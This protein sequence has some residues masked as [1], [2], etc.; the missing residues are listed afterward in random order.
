MSNR[1]NSISTIS[2]VRTILGM[3]YITTALTMGFLDIYEFVLGAV[4]V[5][6]STIVAIIIILVSMHNERVAAEKARRQR[7]TMS[8]EENIKTLNQTLASY[9]EITRKLSESGE[10][11]GAVDE[12]T[13]AFQTSKR[14]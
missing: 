4:V 3:I 14:A 7:E 11:E 9:S 1:N 13:R 2:A 8:L 10:V 5:I 12:L 6:I